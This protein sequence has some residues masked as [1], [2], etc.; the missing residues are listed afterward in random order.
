MVVDVEVPPADVRDVDVEAPDLHPPRRPDGAVGAAARPSL[1][2]V[3][4]GHDGLNDAVDL[5]VERGFFG[6]TNNA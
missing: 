4:D 3:A 6:M 1:V 2:L 5:F